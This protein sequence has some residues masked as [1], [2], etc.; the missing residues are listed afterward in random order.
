MILIRYKIDPD[1]ASSLKYDD[2]VSMKVLASG[3]LKVY[4][5]VEFEVPPLGSKKEPIVT[6]PERVLAVINTQYIMTRE[7]NDEV[8]TFGD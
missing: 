8:P 3:A 2:D 6:T 7:A 4:L 5:P 1:F